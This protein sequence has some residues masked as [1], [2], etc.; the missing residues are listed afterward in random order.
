MDAE[1]SL[2]KAT[3]LVRES[4]AIKLQQTTLRLDDTMDVGAVNR[5]PFQRHGQQNK[6]SLKP[7]QT[8]PTQPSV[9]RCG[10]APHSR[11]QCPARDQSTLPQM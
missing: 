4:E 7:R 2:D 8:P 9:T 6:Q 11:M 5:K 1:L 3:K 10:Q